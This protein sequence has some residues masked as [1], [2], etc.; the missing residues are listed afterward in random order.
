MTA[1]V[2][3]VKGNSFEVVSITVPYKTKQ[4]RFANRVCATWRSVEEVAAAPLIAT[5]LRASGR[6]TSVSAAS[7]YRG[8]LPAGTE[9]PDE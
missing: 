1:L 9:K 5:V 3:D 6:R 8:N 2:G 7:A 4:F